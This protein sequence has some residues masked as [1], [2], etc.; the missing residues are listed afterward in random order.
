MKTQLPGAQ[1]TIQRARLWKSRTGAHLERELEQFN[2]LDL[3]SLSPYQHKVH[4]LSARSARSGIMAYDNLANLALAGKEMM[5]ETSE[6]RLPRLSVEFVSEPALRVFL[7][8]SAALGALPEDPEP[9]SRMAQASGQRGGIN[10]EALEAAVK[11][12]SDAQP[13]ITREWIRSACE[14]IATTAGSTKLDTLASSSQDKVTEIIE[15]V[16]DERLETGIGHRF[17]VDRNKILQDR[18][19]L[20]EALENIED[21]LSILT[22]DQSGAGQHVPA[23]ILQKIGQEADTLRDLVRAAEVS[24]DQSLDED[25]MDYPT[26]R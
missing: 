3:A 21:S 10:S 25:V 16:Y 11:D 20:L 2:G 19:E 7:R 13:M 12:W 1:T 18:N 9:L 6:S 5:D 8:S 4:E 14:A 24:Q 22:N 15:Q 23:S 26:P 17:K